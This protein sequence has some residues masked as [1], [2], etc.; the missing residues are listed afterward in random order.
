MMRSVSSSWYLVANRK[1]LA[2][3]IGPVWRM[4]SPKGSSLVVREFAGSGLFTGQYARFAEQAVFRK[5]RRERPDRLSW[6]SG[7]Q[8]NEEADRVP[9]TE[10]ILLPLPPGN[11]PFFM[12]FRGAGSV[13]GSFNAVTSQLQVRLGGGQ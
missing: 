7:Q 6:R 4:T 5:M 11:N 13:H 10:P 3:A 1:G 2:L 9:F 8:L 12:L